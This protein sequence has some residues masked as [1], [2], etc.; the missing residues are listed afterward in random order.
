[1]ESN[2]NI[3]RIQQYLLGQLSREEMH[4]IEREAIDDPLLGDAI[5][6]YRLQNDVNHGRLSL[7]QQRLAHRIERQLRERNRFYFT[8]QRLGIA[9]TAAVLFILVFL[10]FWMKS[11]KWPVAG[12]DEQEKE[13]QVETSI[14]GE[15]PKQLLITSTPPADADRRVVAT[16]VGGWSALG[17]HIQS[18]FDWGGLFAATAVGDKYTLSFKIGDDWKPSNLLVTKGG[19]PDESVNNRLVAEFKRILEAGPIW[20]GVEGYFEL[21]FQR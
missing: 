7:L 12:T 21:E 6:G 3:T 14:I 5:E 4:A 1:M 18:S 9:A 11:G 16:P 17:D 19:E 2:Y 10:L 8:S 15:L 20:R 13:V